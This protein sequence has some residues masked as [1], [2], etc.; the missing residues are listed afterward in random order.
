MTS[1]CEVHIYENDEQKARTLAQHILNMA[2]ELEQKYNF[3]NPNAYLSALNQRKTNILDMQTKDLLTRAKLF[4]GKTDGIFDVTRGT[5][6]QSRKL[7]SIEAIEEA[8]KGLEP[9]IGVEHFKIK[10][11]KLIFDNPHTLID[12]GGFVKEFAVDQA[13]K[14]VKKEKV[15][16][17]L[18]N[19]GGDIY[20]LGLKPN[21]KAFK[22]G[23]KNPLKPSEYLTGVEITNQGL[24]TSAS[25]ERNHSVE[26]KNYSH[27]ISSSK[28]QDEVL[29]ATVIS[30]SVVE[31]GVYSTALM[32]KPTLST[33]LTKILI[34]KEL[35][36]LS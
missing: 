10:K 8:C 4:Y 24:T 35:K 6:T 36:V 12:L 20:A 33:T 29:S 15:S 21:G 9:F 5:L 30:S 28:L 32:I 11:N 34:D 18:I 17:A 31:S 23:I 1:P 26:G 2:K 14:L 27:I 22:V 25:Y 7:S 16:S 13:V 19:F 3:Y